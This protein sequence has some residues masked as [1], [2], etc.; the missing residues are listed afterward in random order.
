VYLVGSSGHTPSV[1]AS[2]PTNSTFPKW[3]ADGRALLFVS[4]RTG[5]PGLWMQS[6][7]DGRP[8]GDPRLLAQDL[9]RVATVWTLTPDEAF[10]YFRQTGLVR[11]ATVALTPDGTVEGT[12]TDI[13][14]G[15]M[16]ATMMPDWAPDGRRLAYQTLF[17]GALSMTLSVL[18]MESGVETHIKT[19]LSGL[20]HPRW[21]PDGNQIVVKGDDVEARSGVFLVDVPNGH[22]TP[23]KVVPANV[24]D[25]LGAVVWGRNGQLVAGDPRGFERIDPR[26]GRTEPLMAFSGSVLGL[27]ESPIDGTIALITENGGSPFV[28]VGEPGGSFRRVLQGDKGEHFSDVQWMPDG[29]TL[30]F[31]RWKPGLSRFSDEH[32]AW[33]VDSRSGT[34]APINLAVGG[35]RELAVTPDGRRLAFTYGVPTR[36][37]WIIEHFLP[38]SDSDAVRET[39]RDH[40]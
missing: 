28:M 12:P 40:D 20:R 22:T 30:L 21:S 11:I 5:S 15:Q 14:T 33:R 18:D 10:I 38:T 36:E 16:G 19:A 3:T 24:D 34:A 9:G 1:V 37:P 32:S 29:H 2:G 23:L 13:P 25:P 7:V 31:V 26:T 4:D 27:A 8:T 17:T 39:S 6:I 35:L